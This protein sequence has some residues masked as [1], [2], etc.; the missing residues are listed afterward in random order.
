MKTEAEPA[1]K[2]SSYVESGRSPKTED[3]VNIAVVQNVYVTSVSQSSVMNRS[4]QVCEI[5]YKLKCNHTTD[6]IVFLVKYFI[7]HSS[8]GL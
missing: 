2:M 5:E 8:E 3:N 7:P 6:T 1:S 4:S